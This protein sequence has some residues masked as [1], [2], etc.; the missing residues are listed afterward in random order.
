M[1]SCHGGAS[2]MWPNPRTVSGLA[3]VWRRTNSSGRRVRVPEL[4]A[5]C[6]G[7]REDPEYRE[8]IVLF[9]VCEE[10]E[11]VWAGYERCHVG[12]TRMLLERLAVRAHRI[13]VP[14]ILGAGLDARTG[15]LQP[16]PGIARSARPPHT[17]THT[18]RQREH[19]A[20]RSAYP[21]D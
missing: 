3:E 16:V 7:P 12:S 21:V 6:R 8:R 2:K 14:D 9:A 4:G 20:L 5:I 13:G 15:S 11:M 17:K 1:G 19:A 10:R 18:L